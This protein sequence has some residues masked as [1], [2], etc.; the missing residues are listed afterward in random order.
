MQVMLIGNSLLKSVPIHIFS[1]EIKEAFPNE[2]D[3][4][5]SYQAAY[6]IDDIYHRARFPESTLKKLCIPT[7][8][9]KNVK[10][11]FIMSLV[12]EISNMVDLEK[13]GKAELLMIQDMVNDL[14]RFCKQVEEE[15]GC[16]VYLFE[17]PQRMENEYKN[18]MTALANHYLKLSSSAVGLQVV[19]L[20][21]GLSDLDADDILQ[22]YGNP[23]DPKYDGIHL[24]GTFSQ[25]QI[26]RHF[27][28]ILKEKLAL[29]F[30]NDFLSPN[31]VL[32][33][34]QQNQLSEQ[35]KQQQQE[36]EQQE[37]QNQLAQQEK[38]N[39]LAQQEKQQQ[40]EKQHAQHTEE[41]V[42]PFQSFLTDPSEVMA[43]V[44]NDTQE[45]HSNTNEGIDAILT[46][47]RVAQPSSLEESKKVCL[48][49]FKTGVCPYAQWCRYSFHTQMAMCSCENQ[50]CRL[51]HSKASGRYPFNIIQTRAYRHMASSREKKY[52]RKLANQ[53]A[54]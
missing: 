19:T 24:R 33:Q 23:D 13:I 30:E 32:Q 25:I 37:K 16:I 53:S 17:A 50:Q 46:M 21:P 10:M 14:V 7:I 5:I 47:V 38:Q 54:V 22:I 51:L 36:K 12:N 3:V 34:E 26:Y 11:C 1:E 28:P 20:L 6:T 48:A 9:N 4:L 27:L 2:E 41:V 18:Y 43:M 52:L 39:Q 35:P 29:Y 44:N 8:K 42:A 45:A 31:S 49:Y 40:Q 15:T